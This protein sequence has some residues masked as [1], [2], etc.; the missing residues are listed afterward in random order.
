M[1]IQKLKNTVFASTTGSASNFLTPSTT[2]Y[3]QAESGAS[4]LGT[5]I[6]NNFNF[7]WKTDYANGIRQDSSAY[8]GA[9]TAPDMGAREFASATTIFQLSD[10]SGGQ[11]TAQNLNV[12]STD[13]QIHKAQLQVAY[14]AGVLSQASFVLNG[15][16]TYTSSDI[17]NFK[18]YW[19]STNTFAT[20]NLLGTVTTIPSAGGTL[21]F[22]GLSQSFAVGTYYLW[23]T[24]DIN[25]VV[26]GATVGHTIIVNG[27][28]SSSVVTSTSGGVTSSTSSTTAS[29][30]QTISNPCAGTPTAGTASVA[31]SPVCPSITTTLS[32]SGTTQASG[33]SYEWHSSTDNFSCK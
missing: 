32:L 4:T 26:G 1:L 9:G 14:G 8:S 7:V 24:T 10:N 18:L 12:N 11:T 3:T 25:S 23:L 6:N 20:T 19:T 5:T 33:I 30:T 13:N 16:S 29:G 21:T 27:M 2:A 15:T 28:T 31:T 17:T 22:S